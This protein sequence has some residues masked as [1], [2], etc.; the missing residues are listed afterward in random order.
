MA[1]AEE[2]NTP[3]E[4]QGE[5]KLEGGTYDIIRGRLT[6]QGN[7]LRTKMEA[8]NATRKEIFGATE[9]KVIATERISTENNC[10][11]RD[12][13]SLGGDRFLFGYNVHIGL[14]S[15]TFIEDV[16]GCFSYDSIAKKFTQENLDDFRDPTFLEDFANLYK[17]YKLT[18]FVKFV[19]L[20]PF[21]HMVFKIGKLTSDIKTFK[22]LVVDGSVKYEG[23][24]S[25]HEYKFPAQHEFEWKKATRDQHR[26]GMHPHISIED[27]VFVETIGGD[28][29][30]KIEDNTDTGKG[31]YEEPVENKDQTLDDA[32]IYFAII[33]NLVLLK[34]KPYQE[35][36]YRYIIYNHKIQEATRADAIENSCILLPNN[37]GVI[38]PKGYYIN[39]GEYKLFDNQIEG[40]LFERRIQAPNGEDF[41]YVFYNREEG[42]YFLLSYNIIAQKV[43]TPIVCSGFT[44][45]DNGEL[46]LFKA[47][48]EAKKHHAI[49]I[50]QT[51]YSKDEQIIE[52]DESNYLAKV[53]NREIVLALAECQELTTL[54]FKE[55]SFANLYVDIVKKTTEILD[56]YHWL[57]EKQAEDIDDS[58]SEIKSTASNAIDEFDKIIRLKKQALEQTQDVEAKTSAVLSR[59][60]NMRVAQVNDIVH[61]LADLRHLKGEIIGLESIRF[62]D[63]NRI[64]ELEEK[65]S[66]AFDHASENCVNFLL[67]KEALD[68]YKSKI[69]AVNKEVT[70]LSKVIVAN[71]LEK[72]IENISREL[73]LLIEIVS[74]LKIL[75]ATK[76]T[77]IID[78]ITALF[79][80]FNKINAELRKKRKALLAV[81]G[82][83]EF[84]A[85]MRLI[86]QGF[87]NYIDISDSP[88]KCEEYLNKLIVQLEELEGKFADFDEYIE[89]IGEK[90]TE[91]YNAFETKK[92]SLTEASN[93]KAQALHKSGERIINGIKNRVAG[94]D[95]VIEINAYY[96]SDLMVDKVRDIIKKLVELKD[97]IKADDLQSKL[98]TTKEDAIR[99]LKDK[100]ELFLD[101]ENTIKLGKH[102][103]LTNSQDLGVTTVFRDND[104][105]YHITGTNFYERIIDQ[106]L[107]VSRSVWEQTIPSENQSVYRGEYLAFKFYQQLKSDVTNETLWFQQTIEERK[108]A[109]TTFA[110]TRF[111]EGYVKGVHDVDAYSIVEELMTKD[112]TIGM[113]RFSSIERTAALLFWK[114]Q[115]LENE[116]MRLEHELKA[117]GILNTVFKNSSGSEHLKKE[118]QKA[119]NE[120]S[121]DGILL[122]VYPERIAAYLL[123]EISLNE[124]FI[125]SPNAKNLSLSFV[126]YLKDQKQIKKWETSL[127]AEGINWKDQFHQMQNWLQTYN[128]N[129]LENK[130]TTDII[131]ETSVYLQLGYQKEL[132]YEV[133]VDVQSE[134][135]GLAGDHATIEGNVYQF[136]YNKFITKLSEFDREIVPKFLAFQHLKNELVVK[137]EQEVKLNE[138]KP[139]VLSSFVRN[140]LID[141]VYLNIIG[142]NLAKQIGT[143][144]ANKRTDLMGLLLLISPPGYGKTT[145]MEYLANRLGLVFMKINGPALGHNIVSLDP[146][147]ADNAASREEIEKLNFGLELGDNIMLYLDDIQHCNPEFLQKFISLCDAQRKIEGVYKG[148]TK[149]YDFRGKK[150]VV[151]MAGNPYTESGDKFKVPDMLIN[152]ADVYNL[153]D[154]LGETDAEFKL[155]YIENSLT[156]NVILAKLAEN[157]K[158]DVIKLIRA[159]EGEP[160]EGLDVKGNYSGEELQEIINLLQKS[161]RVRDILLKVNLEYID[162][163]GKEEVYRT[164]PPFKLQGSYRD[165]NKIVEKLNP[166][167]NDHE[168]QVLINQHYE[169]EAQTLTAGAEANLLKFKELIGIINEVELKRWVTIKEEYVKRQ[170]LK[171][172]GDSN[173]MAQV[174]AQM[175][176]LNNTIGQLKQSGNPEM[177]VQLQALTEGVRAISK[178]MIEQKKAKLE[179]ELKKLNKQDKNKDE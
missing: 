112:S 153:G 22:W 83:A 36:A 28:L 97:A 146:A 115:I 89:Q 101:G 178:V 126:K 91:I 173:E 168:L 80:E 31:I 38:F 128:V 3:E 4:K 132:F 109:V 30:L 14:K 114:F 29:T 72:E 179:A 142:D 40:L 141:K 104:F 59:A 58:L 25:E 106:Q 74:N 145:L 87:I 32:E 147:D 52:I 63:K 165:M 156:S 160:I 129:I 39:T 157:D 151:V 77:E 86:N 82:K 5:V 55:D 139:R 90:R 111:N 1:E 133:Q 60:K 174:I 162:S 127:F 119:F 121:M 78:N 75:D 131:L 164:E 18:R 16:F 17:Y 137:F 175:D 84:S 144:G 71:D 158:S 65:V 34:I 140:Q 6:K 26:S 24:R 56:S 67:K 100:K 49:Q 105:Y 88:E 154:I 10:E 21:L 163:A 70:E 69:T 93:K 50:W 37:Q 68:P 120:K 124:K 48:T 19:Q 152:R 66:V 12:I 33:D 2:N 85:Q 20:G 107:E 155:S 166:M 117:E 149:T 62:V 169:G 134:L 11:A 79:A 47:D 171:G 123:N 118:L 116:R 43:D 176:V 41:L 15:E 81:E 110:S 161:L 54:I 51:V 44:L 61:L 35:E 167:M 96:A 108:H 148:K 122:N 64:K 9:T 135:K 42:V 172:Y 13:I 113:L 177:M 99:Q 103:F 7:A 27:I 94:F 46:A 76:T 150:M 143:A 23:N 130:F 92:V 53:G 98:K 95:D 159:A 102:A 170:R 57:S 136:H 45:F 125:V 73:E 8:L 138:F